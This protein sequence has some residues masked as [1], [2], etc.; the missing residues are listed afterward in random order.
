[1]NRFITTIILSLI[2]T[3]AFAIADTSKIPIPIIRVH[4]HDLI[5]EAQKRCDKTDG[6]QD[7]MI[8][9]SGNDE[10][11]LQVTDAIMRKVNALEDFVEADTLIASNNE[12]VRYLRY[13]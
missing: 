5:D 13:I 8:K 6:K 7:G 3:G 10:I 2:A 4:F 11:N 1:M 9:V 12:K